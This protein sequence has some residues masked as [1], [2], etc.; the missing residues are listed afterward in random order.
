[1]FS[2]L[3]DNGG[4][5]AS[6]MFGL[7]VVTFGMG[8]WITSMSMYQPHQYP[9][10]QSSPK[11]Y[12][13]GAVSQPVNTVPV[14]EKKEPC[15]SPTGSDES[16]LCAQWRA[17]DAAERS[18]QYAWWQMV[19]SIVGIL[20]LAITLWFN[21]QAIISA[22]TSSSE[23][24]RLG[25]AQVR[26]YVS[27]ET[28]T[29][30]MTPFGWPSVSLHI[31][32]SGQSPARHFRWDYIGIVTPS[33]PSDVKW[34]SGDSHISDNG[35]FIDVPPGETD[36]KEA[37]KGANMTDAILK[38]M[39]DSKFGS[40]RVSVNAQWRDVFGNLFKEVFEFQGPL[41]G[42]KLEAGIRLH[43]YEVVPLHRPT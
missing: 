22:Y 37:I 26:C 23:A 5:I 17:V 40:I 4:L 14:S 32:N 20:G 34:N 30:Y 15:I 28:C 21:K 31:K 1:V 12:G 18:A 24:R 3:R 25:E 2:V 39:I 7:M 16:E 9:L 13:S 38:G 36:T 33:G 29:F 6:A 11:R 42:T 10:Y 41:D 43:Q 19:I 35:N 8:C 27:I